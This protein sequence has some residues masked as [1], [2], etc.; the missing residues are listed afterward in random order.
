[1][2]EEC[3]ASQCVLLDFHRAETDTLPKLQHS[4]RFFGSRMKSG[5]ETE[6][7]AAVQRIRTITAVNSVSVPDSCGCFSR[8]TP[9]A[10]RSPRK[11]VSRGATDHRNA[12]RRVNN[13]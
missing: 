8:G 7:T 5:T 13:G 10:L 2:Q 6:L 1:M 12:D 3:H 11:A 9:L 4:C